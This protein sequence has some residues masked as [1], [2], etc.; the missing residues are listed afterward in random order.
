[1]DILRPLLRNIYKFNPKD[2]QEGSSQPEDELDIK[3]FSPPPELRVRYNYWEEMKWEEIISKTIHA[4]LP[5]S[6]EDHRRQ[7]I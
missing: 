5:A 3:P 7:K 4:E 6:A 2:R 1:M